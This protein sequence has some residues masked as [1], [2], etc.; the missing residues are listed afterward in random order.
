MDQN[1][2]QRC[3]GTTWIL[4]VKDAPSPPYR[5]GMK[6]EFGARCPD[7]YEHPRPTKN[8]QGSSD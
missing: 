8:K 3:S 6:L 7:C 5:E 4:Y 1:N 2:C